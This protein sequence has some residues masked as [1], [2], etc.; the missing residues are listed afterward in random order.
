LP[1]LKSLWLY[2]NPC[3]QHE[4]YREIVIHHLPNL[5]KLDNTMVTQEEKTIASNPKFELDLSAAP[6]VQESG[7]Y[8]N[9]PEVVKR[10][11]VHSEARKQRPYS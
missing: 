6:A 11:D 8:Q 5:T 10:S 9:T 1:Y 2:D 7:Y 3:A 4:N